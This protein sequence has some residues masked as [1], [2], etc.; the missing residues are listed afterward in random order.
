MAVIDVDAWLALGGTTA[1]LTS[2]NV[3]AIPVRTVHH[4]LMELTNTHVNAFQASPG[5]IARR[6][7]TNVLHRLVPMMVFVLILLMVLNA[8][9][10][11][12]ITM[13]DASVMSTNALPIPAY[14]VDAKTVSINTFVIAHQVTAE[15]VAKL[16]LTSA[17]RIPASMVVSV[18]TCLTLILALVCLATPEAIVRSTSTIAST[19]HAETAEHA[20]IWLTPT[21]VCAEFHLPDVI[22]NR[23]W[24]PAHLID[25]AMELVVLQAKTI[26]TSTAHVRSVT[27]DAYVMKTSTNANGRHLHAEIMQLVR[28]SMDPINAYVR[29]VMKAKIALTTLMS[30]SRSLVKT[31][32]PVRT[33]SAITF[34]DVMKDSRAR[35]AR[36][37]S[38]NASHNHV[39]TEPLATN[40]SI[41]TLALVHSVFL[42]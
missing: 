39:K 1:K 28:T 41:L 17:D 5:F 24:I 16:R 40:T 31:A 7:S 3:T 30:A 9:V 19:N 4:A 10:L 23:K 18:L 37:T 6:T 35:I 22:V 33:A 26:K 13:P 20:L 12:D 15:N 42:E 29:R 2:M 32:V 25:A 14:M 11:R 38:M 34:V 36:P 8:S 27:R 21:N